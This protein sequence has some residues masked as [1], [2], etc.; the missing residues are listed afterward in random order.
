MNLSYV[1]AVV[2]LLLEFLTMMMLIVTEHFNV[3]SYSRR[4]ALPEFHQVQCALQM[5]CTVCA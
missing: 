4:C 3:I 5:I 2:L 1:R